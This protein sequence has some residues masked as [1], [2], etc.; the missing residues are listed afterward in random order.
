V[1]RDDGTE[2]GLPRNCALQ[3]PLLAAELD[4]FSTF[5]TQP[6]TDSQENP[7][8]P[9]TAEVYLRHAKLFLGWYVHEHNAVDPRELS[10]YN[11]IPTK[12]KESADSFISFLLWLR[13]TRHISVSYEANLL[14]GLTK[15]LK[16]RFRKDSTADPAYGDKSFDD[17]PV[18]RE[19]RKLH[20]E[21]NKRQAVAPRSSEEGRKWLSWP[22][23]LGVV[24]TTKQEVLA[25]L[26]EHRASGEKDP[27]ADDADGG[28]YSPMH[29]K[30]ATAFQKYLI[31]AI[32]ANVPDRQRTIRELEIGRSFVKDGQSNTWCIKH[33][34]EDY[35]TGDTYGERPSMYLPEV[36]TASIDDFIKRWRPCFRPKHNFLFC[37]VRT[38]NPL[39][40][41]SV[42]QSVARSCYKH[43]GKRTN[44]HLLRDM[45]VTH[46][47]E[48]SDASEQQLEAL[49]LYMGHSI[50]IQRASY[51]RRTLAKKVAPAVELMQHVNSDFS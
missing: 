17:I 13:K 26:E 10:I 46:V 12:E 36:L 38:G 43:T 1:A 4:D 40:Q 50:Q 48:S 5:M 47:R 14:R 23:Y 41:D 44:P 7:V 28:A 34:P 6:S 21:A 37:Q 20:R 49:A 27:P 3:Y 51:D 29:R 18:V 9:A 2:Y 24:Q 39:T 31:L 35:K 8:R 11:V 16:F 22:E 30:I 25:L 45:I 15:L 42:Y 19:L 32:F 33:A